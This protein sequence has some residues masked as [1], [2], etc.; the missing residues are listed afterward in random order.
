MGFNQNHLDLVAGMHTVIAL[1]IL[2]VHGATLCMFT[3]E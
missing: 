2:Y 1:T 3:N